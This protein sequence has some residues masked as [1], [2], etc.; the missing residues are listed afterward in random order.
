MTGAA[1]QFRDGDRVALLVT[2]QGHA[3]GLGYVRGAQRDGLVDVELD[4]YGFTVIQVEKLKLIKRR[5]ADLEL[6]GRE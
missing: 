2:R 4:R 5:G 3:M 1:T 6:D